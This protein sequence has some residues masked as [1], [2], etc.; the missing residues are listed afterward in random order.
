ML[1]GQAQVVAKYDA[2]PNKQFA[3]VVEPFL[4]ASLVDALFVP[5]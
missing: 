1:I 3:L 2:K 4:A 5:K